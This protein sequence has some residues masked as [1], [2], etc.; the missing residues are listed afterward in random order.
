M[1]DLRYIACNACVMHV[2]VRTLGC[3][4]NLPNTV[5]RYTEKK[6]LVNTDKPVF[7]FS[8]NRTL[9]LQIG[10]TGITE[11]NSWYLAGI[12]G[13]TEI[14]KNNNRYLAG[15]TDITENNNRYLAGITDITENRCVTVCPY[16]LKPESWRW[17][18]KI[19]VI[20]VNRFTDTSLVRTLLSNLFIGRSWS[21]G[22]W[23]SN[24]RLK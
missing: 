12:T 13:I 18:K 6:Y 8:T 2:D 7:V 16:L 17:K 22:S 11:N 9:K 4:G 5:L 14:T 1:K 23:K 15:I 20:P 19:P 3:N 24:V 10:W 21:L